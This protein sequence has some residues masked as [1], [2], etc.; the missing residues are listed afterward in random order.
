MRKDFILLSYHT[1][2]SKSDRKK[3]ILRSL[4]NVNLPEDRIYKSYPC[5][6]SGGQLQR[7]A[8]A[9]AM[10]L[11]P[12]LLVADEPTTALDSIT[13]A[14]VL[15]LIADLKEQTNCAVLFI[16]HDLRHVRKYAN[17]IAVMLD[18]EI[19]ESGEADVIFQQPQH[20]Y[21]KQLLA[22]IPSLRETPSRLLSIDRNEVPLV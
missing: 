10:I 17:K 11:K 9:M 19:V 22:A 1:D 15:K 8:I 20:V 13:A 18:G 12:K 7:A 2:R 21:T 4:K 3:A 6:L 5:Q 16:T 14:K